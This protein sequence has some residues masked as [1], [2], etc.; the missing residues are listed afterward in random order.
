M[1]AGCMVESSYVGKCITEAKAAY[2]VSESECY[3]VVSSGYSGVCSD[4][5]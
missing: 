3:V 2:C 5:W 4:G 1:S